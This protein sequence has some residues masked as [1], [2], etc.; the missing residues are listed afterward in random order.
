MRPAA[1]LAV[2]SCVLLAGCG[3]SSGSPQGAGASSAGGRT[4]EELWSAAPERVAVVPGDENHEPGLNRVSFLVVDGSGRVVERPSA[5]V[6]VATSRDAEPFLRTK[7]VLER[8]GVLGGSEADAT[9]FYVAHVRLPKPHTYWLL[10]EPVGGRQI[11][12]IGN[13][14]VVANDSPPDVGDPAPRSRTPTIASTHGDFA[15]LTTRTPP[16]RALLRYSVADSL[17]AH[18]PFV[19]TFA[20]PKLCQSRLCG[21]SVDVTLAA[22]RRFRGDGIRFIH[23]EVYENND[24]AKGFNRWMREWKL[25]TEPWTFLVDRSGR[26]VDR[27]EGA[28]SVDEL[29]RA[30]RAKLLES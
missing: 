23:V 24:L 30:V 4:L 27:F 12:A 5:T 29:E 1:A 11:A 8:I 3:G 22:E 6:W 10:A 13:V 14:Q 18:V 7:A 28:L 9:H 2:V 17:S 15:A 21:P 25:E 26:I 19:V 20:T 16:D